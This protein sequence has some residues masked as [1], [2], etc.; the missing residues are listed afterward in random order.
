MRKQRIKPHFFG[1]RKEDY[2]RLIELGMTHA[3]LNVLKHNPARF[4][5]EFSRYTKNVTDEHKAELYMLAFQ[6]ATD[7]D[8]AR[9]DSIIYNK[10][11]RKE[12]AA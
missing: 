2:E 1:M 10:R 6:I 5:R 12:V 4:F 11:T 8:R 9:I 7:K 3:A